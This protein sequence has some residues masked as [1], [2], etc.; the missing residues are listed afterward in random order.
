MA[1]PTKQADIVVIHE[2]YGTPKN[3]N[4]AHNHITRATKDS[5][6]K[7]SQVDEIMIDGLSEVLRKRTTLN[8]DADGNLLS[9]TEQVFGLDGISV[10]MEYTDTLDKSDPTQLSVERVVV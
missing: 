8:R 2:T 3:Y 9:V 5:E 1:A 4:K 7:T 6:G 10:E